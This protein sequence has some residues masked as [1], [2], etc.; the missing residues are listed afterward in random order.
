[1]TKINYV[2]V[3]YDQSSQKSALIVSLIGLLANTD[4]KTTSRG[5]VQVLVTVTH[6]K[7]R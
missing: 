7:C 3:T 5:L 6:E 1:M 2:E 4:N